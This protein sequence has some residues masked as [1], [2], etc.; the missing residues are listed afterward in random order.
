[1]NLLNLPQANLG[2]TL[3]KSFAV[4]E[5]AHAAVD[6]MNLPYS[7][8]LHRTEMEAIGYIAQRVYSHHLRADPL[9]RHWPRLIHV[10]DAIARRVVEAEPHLYH[11]TQDE[12][13]SLRNA[14]GKHPKYHPYRGSRAPS[15]G[16]P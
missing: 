10:A 6:L 11:V 2:T 8:G 4:H 9:Q 1:M 16:I 14:I 15:D 13:R 3:D 5:L 12:I 7:R